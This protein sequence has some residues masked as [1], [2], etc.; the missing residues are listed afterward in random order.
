LVFSLVLHARKLRLNFS[1]EGN[2][3]EENSK[4][5]LN[6]LKEIDHERWFLVLTVFSNIGDIFPTVERMSITEEILFTHVNRG[7]VAFFG[8][9]SAIMDLIKAYM[10][11]N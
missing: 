7:T 11:Q 4:G 6:R 2:V 8:M 3:M 1:K 5:F 9:I 10:F